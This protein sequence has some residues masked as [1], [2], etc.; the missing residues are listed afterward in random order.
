M[1][2]GRPARLMVLCGFAL[3]LFSAIFS[4]AAWYDW[5]PRLPPGAL[6]DTDLWAGFLGGAALL[7][8]LLRR[9]SK[10]IESPESGGETATGSSESEL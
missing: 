10:K 4:L 8:L 6:H 1:K 9:G 3:I 7:L 5:W 2:V